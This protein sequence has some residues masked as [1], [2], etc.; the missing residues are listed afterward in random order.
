MHR[1]YVTSLINDIDKYNPDSNLIDENGHKLLRNLKNKHVNI[2]ISG[3]TGSGKS[4]T[5]NTLFNTRIAKVETS[6][7]PETIDI[8]K[9]KLP[10]LNILDTPGIVGNPQK[11]KQNKDNIIR[12]LVKTDPNDPLY[13]DL[14]L[15][16]IDCSHN[17]FSPAYELIDSVIVPN[18][19]D[20]KDRIIIALNKC[21][22]A[23]GGDGWDIQNAQPNNELLKKL[24]DNAE[25]V[26][27]R[28]NELAGIDI[29]PI[30]YSTGHTKDNVN[31]K[32]YNMSKLLVNI[33]ERIP[34]EKRLLIISAMSQDRETWMSNDGQI[35]YNLKIETY[36]KEE[37]DQ[38]SSS[39][40]SESSS[41]SSIGDSLIKTG[42]NVICDFIKGLF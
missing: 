9:Y 28:I 40:S 5:I 41:E 6:K 17:D 32:P 8:Q 1:Y 38:Y 33:I 3:V 36:F 34:K 20:N 14:V 42:L 23:D 11:D 13:I 2:L 29:A 35:D 26:R 19:G 25:K 16:I 15:V 24:E 30:Y 31:Y 12:Q 21:D 22:I 27:K 37:T 18:L 7:E 39:T 10:R 4:S